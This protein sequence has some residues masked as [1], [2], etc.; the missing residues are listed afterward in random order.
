MPH[1]HGDATLDACGATP[2]GRMMHLQFAD[3]ETLRRDHS[4]WKLL[5]A[6]YAPLLLS[7]LHRAFVAS[8]VRAIEQASLVEML[9]DELFSLRE[10]K[11]EDAYSQSALS[12]LMQWSHESNGWLRRFYVNA[13]DEPFYDITPDTEKAVAWIQTLGARAFTGTESRVRTMFD[14]L[15]QISAGSETDPKVRIAELRAE[16]DALDAHIEALET[17]GVVLM[18]E[19]AIKER[20]LQFIDSASELMTAFREIEHN[21]RDFDR[22]LRAKIATG[23]A[24]KGAVVGQIIDKRDEISNTDQGKSFDAFLAFL[25]SSGRQDEFSRLLQKALSL[26]SVQSIPHD[27][28]IGRVHEQ[29]REAAERIQST[30]SH[31]MRQLRCYLDDGAWL[32]NRRI[33]EIISGIENKSI[34]LLGMQPGGDV[35]MIEDTSATVDLL[36]E[37]R[38]YKVPVKS[39]VCDVVLEGGDD[40]FDAQHLY[41]HRSINRDKLAQNIKR[42]L[43]ETGHIT[44][45]DLCQKHPL[46][47]GLMELV[48]YLDLASGALFTTTI[49]ETIEDVVEWQVMDDQ[50]NPQR[51]RAKMARVLFT[52]DPA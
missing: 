31:L 13:S 40:Q 25:M 8:G 22:K 18:D 27:P 10:I 4:G 20:F 44:L 35:T 42:T 11:G 26:P 32:D 23:A 34:A 29:W 38:L 21:F 9:E 1:V 7:F 47:Q 36:M 24:N 3:I 52:Q 28:S 33:M 43:R 51:V 6:D 2:K 46:T 12:Y 41:S 48:S 49:D 19:T 17:N 5:R 14:L 45:A 16:R 30:K 15:N 50:Q 39:T 37:R